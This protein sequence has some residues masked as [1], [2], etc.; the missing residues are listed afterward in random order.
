M[1]YHLPY[2]IE[3]APV[4]KDDPL[5]LVEVKLSIPKLHPLL[6]LISK[7]RVKLDLHLLFLLGAELQLIRSLRK[8]AQLHRFLLKDFPKQRFG[9][10]P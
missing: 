4:V 9:T 8:H 10:L 2:G 6:T 3:G 1:E 7:G 5:F